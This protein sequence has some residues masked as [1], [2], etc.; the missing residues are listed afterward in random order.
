MKQRPLVMLFSAVLLLGLIAPQTMAATRFAVFSDPHFYDNDLGTEG[1]AFEAYLLQDRKL[2]RESEALVQAAVGEILA[3]HG[4]DPIDFVIVP[5]DLTKD[6][7]RTSHE[8]FADYLALIE[9]AGI[10]VF[11]AP[12]N[13]DIN[14]PHAVAYDGDTV[15]SVDTVSPVEFASIYGPFGYDE[16]LIHDPD[17]LSYAVEAAPGV[18]LLSLDSCKYD[19]NLF[20][21]HPETSGALKAATLEWALKIIKYARKAGKQVVAFQHHGLTEHYLG[22]SQAFAEYVIDDWE[23]VSAS[24][25]DA[26]LKLAFTGHYHANDI[27]AAAGNEDGATLY[28]VETGSLVTAPCPYRIITLHGNNAAQVETRYITAI[29]YDTGGMPFPD[30]AQAFLY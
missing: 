15:S 29:D 8:K 11:V 24:L 25:A 21:G 14:N 22:Q 26:G 13:H 9:E 4:T 30:Y 27:T 18:I 28:D 5:G 19:D 7:E 16:A 17:S 12:G 23:T 6:G 3:A 10:P 2:L 20:T 1:T